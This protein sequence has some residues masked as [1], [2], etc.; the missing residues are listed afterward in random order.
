MILTLHNNYKFDYLLQTVTS[1]QNEFQMSS[2]S[3]IV[4]IWNFFAEKIFA[5]LHIFIPID[6]LVPDLKINLKT[7]NQIL[8]YHIELIKQTK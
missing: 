8:L 5:Y 4:A 3:H 2:L 1:K 7:I 6:F